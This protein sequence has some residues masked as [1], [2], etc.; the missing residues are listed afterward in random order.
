MYDGMKLQYTESMSHLV[1]QKHTESGR[2]NSKKD[3][4][5]IQASRTEIMDLKTFCD[6]SQDAMINKNQ[7]IQ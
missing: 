6:V 3:N 5:E 2:K 7:F 4:G 1:Q